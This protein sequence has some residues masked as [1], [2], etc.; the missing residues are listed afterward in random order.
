MKHTNAS[1]LL[2]VIMLQRKDTYV[3]KYTY[4]PYTDRKYSIPYGLHKLA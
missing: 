3:L 2:V 4:I 1:S